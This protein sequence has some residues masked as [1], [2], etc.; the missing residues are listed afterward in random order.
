MNAMEAYLEDLD[1]DYTER[2]ETYT[3]TR[4]EI[5]QFARE[6]DPEL[7][8]TDEETADS[9]MYNGLTASSSH[10]L[11]LTY[12]LS[13]WCRKRVIVLAPLEIDSMV[14]PNAARPEDQLSYRYTVLEKRK[15]KSKTDRGIIK[16]RAELLNERDEIILSSYQTL[17]IARR[18]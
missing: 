5:I 13:H 3:L 1:V 16:I 11:A 7:F 15:S 18:T 2:T 6:Y 4:E 17:L 14:F 8:H 12:K 10:S 9:S